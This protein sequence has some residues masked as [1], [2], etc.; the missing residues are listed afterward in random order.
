MVERSPAMRASKK[1]VRASCK[2][3]MWHTHTR[4][5]SN[6]D[7]ACSFGRN[8]DKKAMMEFQESHG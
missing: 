4:E 1:K 3:G 8:R 2:R 7:K 5:I 6:D